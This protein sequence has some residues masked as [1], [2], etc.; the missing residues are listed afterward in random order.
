MLLVS[1]HSFLPFLLSKWLRLKELK[2]S[3]ASSK[4]TMYT[5]MARMPIAIAGFIPALIANGESKTAQRHFGAVAIKAL[6]LVQHMGGTLALAFSPAAK[7]GPKLSTTE[8]IGVFPHAPTALTFVKKV[9]VAN[10]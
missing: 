5:Y 1:W 2:R 10:K 4:E 7:H 9:F 6:T 3:A 8:R